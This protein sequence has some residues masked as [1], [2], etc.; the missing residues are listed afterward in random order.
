MLDL[1]IDSLDL[2]ELSQT[3]I[4]RLRNLLR[5]HHCLI[6]HPCLVLLI[7]KLLLLL[8]L[9]L[10]VAIK[11]LL[12][13]LTVS[14]GRFKAESVLSRL[15]LLTH[16]IVLLRDIVLEFGKRLVKEIFLLN[17]IDLFELHQFPLPYFG[18][19]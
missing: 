7:L 16:I 15:Y 9:P 14:L 11:A 17:L 8:I 1:I 2:L 12:D 10:L 6:L 18:K 4:D 5:L 13:L 3:L 19:I